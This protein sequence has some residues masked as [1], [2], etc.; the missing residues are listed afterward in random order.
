MRRK[1][2]KWICRVEVKGLKI[3]TG[4]RNVFGCDQVSRVEQKGKWPCIL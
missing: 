2:V 4:N 1:I 3:N